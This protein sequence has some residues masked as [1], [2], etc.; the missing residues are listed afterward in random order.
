MVRTN[1]A[2]HHRRIV[3]DPKP[4]RPRIRAY[5]ARS[6]TCSWIDEVAGKQNSTGTAGSGIS[7][8]AIPV[9]TRSSSRESVCFYRGEKWL[10]QFKPRVLQFVTLMLAPSF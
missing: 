6:A 8:G 4:R 5:V 2:Y 7:T 3:F 9:R 10:A 1:L